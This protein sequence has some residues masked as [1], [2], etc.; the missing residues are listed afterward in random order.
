MI[1]DFVRQDDGLLITFYDGEVVYLS[2][3]EKKDRD[4]FLG[5]KKY[6]GNIALIRTFPD[7]S[8]VTIVYSSM[9]QPIKAANT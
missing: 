5:E 7:S 9:P 6:T 3:G 2:L 8:D 4:I 1:R